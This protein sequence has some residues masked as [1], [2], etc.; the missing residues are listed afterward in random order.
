MSALKSRPTAV[1]D[2]YARPWR[3]L[4]RHRASKKPS[5][6]ALQ[7]Q[8]PKAPSSFDPEDA[9][10]PSGSWIFF[11]TSQPISRTGDDSTVLLERKA[12]TTVVDET[13]CPACN[14][15]IELSDL[16][17][18]KLYTALAR[19]LL[20][21]ASKDVA[22]PE[23]NEHGRVP[24][25]KARMPG[26][27]WLARSTPFKD[28]RIIRRDH[29]RVVRC[30]TEQPAALREHIFKLGSYLEYIP[31]QRRLIHLDA[32]TRSL[33]EL[34]DIVVQLFYFLGRCIRMCPSGAR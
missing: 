11:V 18:C 34:A 2:R 25:P 32:R 28:D 31:D 8:R 14:S 27:W 4:K 7:S 17:A 1:A 13:R 5:D 30:H 12:C 21:D 29:G 22:W 23:C 10:L 6:S 16:V 9:A 24:L 15:S 19:E 3:E 33:K 20:V 26:S